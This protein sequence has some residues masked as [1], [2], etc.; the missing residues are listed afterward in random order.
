MSIEYFVFV[1][2]VKQREDKR[3]EA[4][5]IGKVPII[6]EKKVQSH[7]TKLLR[8]DTMNQQEVILLRHIYFCYF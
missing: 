1:L 8:P 4:L 3:R 7:P 2:T 6:E 5:K